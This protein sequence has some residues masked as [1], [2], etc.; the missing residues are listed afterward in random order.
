MIITG[1]Y[2]CL[3]DLIEDQG[4][5]ALIV[6]VGE[7]GVTSA[8]IK[9][10]S[11]PTKAERFKKTE[12]QNLFLSAS[13]KTGEF[14]E[15]KKEDKEILNVHL[16]KVFGARNEASMN[17][18]NYDL[19]SVSDQGCQTLNSYK[20][21]LEQGTQV[22][23]ANMQMCLNELDYRKDEYE[24]LGVFKYKL[25]AVKMKPIIGEL[26]AKYRIERHIRGDPLENM[27]KLSPNPPDFVPIGRYT[28][29]GKEVID[30]IHSDEFLW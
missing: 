15:K 13:V 14:T 30:K 24:P 20:S 2:V 28:Q 11:L 26:P 7:D 5:V 1:F 23:A 6:D 4:E 17:S 27:P 3:K 16:A 8:K 25:V 10:Y 22:Y 9:E 18:V 29:E 19:T 21:K 12:I